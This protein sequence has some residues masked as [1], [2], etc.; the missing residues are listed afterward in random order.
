MNKKP[1]GEEYPLYGGDIVLE[2]Q[3]TRHIYS[4]G[5]K[6]VYGVTGVTG[7]LPKDW[8]PFYIR[9][10]AKMYYK[11]NAAG[12]GE[13]SCIGEASFNEA[14]TAS[15]RYGKEAAQ[16][17]T[18]VHKFVQDWLEN[19][20]IPTTAV[21]EEKNSLSAF[22]FFLCRNKLEPVFLERK[23]YSKEH[24]Y[25]GTIDFIG[26][27]NGKITIIDWKTSERLYSSYL[28]QANAYA[29]AIGE[30]IKADPKLKKK[31]GGEIEQI[32]IVRLGKNGK[33]ETIIQ[34][35]GDI[36]VFLHLLEVKHWLQTNK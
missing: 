1:Q 30:E 27:L 28:L 24:Q 12:S 23:C 31:I 21:Q 13:L 5:G 11:E 14:L 36:K 9:K 34:K 15:D 20:T 33:S 16:K 29:H 22:W 6:G 25:A 2:Y 19:E 26:K 3:P 7:I 35:V 4:V 8:M 32:A 10:H 18:N 17:G